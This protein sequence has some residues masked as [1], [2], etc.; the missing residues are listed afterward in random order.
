MEHI[1][2]SVQE[3]INSFNKLPGVGPKTAKKFAYHLL[4]QSQTENEKFAQAII[5]IKKDTRQ[6]QKCFS[7]S[8]QDICP[9]C[10][11]SKRDQTILCLVADV[12]DLSALEKSGQYQG[13][14]FILGGV[15]DQPNGIGP[16]ALNLKALEERLKK[17]DIKEI[18]IATNPD[19]EGETT[20]LYLSKLLKKYPLKITRLARGLPLGSDIE[21]A[22][23]ITLA[24]AITNRHEI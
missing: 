20:A 7:L 17:E 3:L 10:K 13:L 1:P 4:T 2:Y 21:Y 18:I 8:E 23:E 12:L 19:M 15:I 14:Y 6:C 5:Q 16:E 9:I 24:G 22:D 11:D